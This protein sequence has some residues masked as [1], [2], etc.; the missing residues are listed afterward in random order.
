MASVQTHVATPVGVIGPVEIG[1][2][3]LEIA[4]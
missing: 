1:G 4:S 3:Q 2:G